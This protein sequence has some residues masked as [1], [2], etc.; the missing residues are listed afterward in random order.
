MMWGS[1]LRHRLSVGPAPNRRRRCRYCPA[2]A[3][4]AATHVGY[5]NGVAMTQGCE[6]HVHKWF[7]DTLRY[8]RAL[9]KGAIT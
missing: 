6:W 8:R 9:P 7:N 4:K 2:N 5:A 3:R 1:V